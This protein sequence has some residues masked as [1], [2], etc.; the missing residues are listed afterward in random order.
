VA[1]DNYLTS[2]GGSGLGVY[3]SARTHNGNYGLYF[4]AD[5]TLW[6]EHGKEDK[7]GQGLVG[8]FRVAEAPK[9]RNLAQLGVDGGLVYK[10]LIPG[11]DWDTLALGVSYLEMSS[12]IRRAQEDINATLASVGQSPAFSVLA[13]YEA[14]IELSY[15]FQ[16]A[17]W[18]TVQPSIQRVLHPGGRTLSDTPDAT[19]FILQT[20][21]RF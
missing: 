16:L 10:G 13:D 3:T 2:L 19:V 9:N 17:A 6:R 8:F 14:V 15:K 5:Q 4:L 11:R 12:E 18:W 21:L 1:V 20:T 7:A